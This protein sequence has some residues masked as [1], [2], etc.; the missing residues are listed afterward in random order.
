MQAFPSFALNDSGSS[1]R[2]T[3]KSAAVSYILG[4][5]FQSI[6]SNLPDS[7]HTCASDQPMFSNGLYL[8][9]S[10]WKLAMI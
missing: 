9:R 10:K 6:E 3:D 4:R 1:V 5:C 7:Q 8:E 2:H